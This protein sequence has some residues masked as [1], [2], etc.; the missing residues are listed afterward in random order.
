MRDEGGYRSQREREREG[1]GEGEGREQT[2]RRPA[3]KSWPEF[4][5]SGQLFVGA[6]IVILGTALLLDNL[7]VIESTRQILR[8]W[9]LVLIAAGINDLVAARHRGRATRGTLLAA[10]GVLFLLN[11]LNVIDFRVWDL[12]PLFL[13]LFGFKMLMR[14]RFG[15][16]N[17]S[18]ILDTSEFDDFAFL[19]GVKR[20]NS[21]SS[22][23]G[24]AATAFM[25]GV[26]LD[27][28]K[29]KME[30][31]RAVI[32]VLAMMGGIGIRIPDDWTV[33]SKVMA[34]LGGVDDK[35]RPPEEPT[36]TLVI[37]GTVICGGIEI[38][39]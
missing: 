9:P 28:H 36:K 19:G 38:K 16:V 10:F 25:G 34:F 3:R 29:A 1:E 4:R 32:N 31:D 20:S 11:N 8:F 2:Q 6:A 22:F 37:Q 12:W 5:A 17:E 24:G 18:V 27:L 35:T 21:S 23:R 15:S 14:S 33:D 39:D 7:G 30:G 13:I 26:D